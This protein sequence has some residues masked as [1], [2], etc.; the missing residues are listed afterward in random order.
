MML[1]FVPKQD[2]ASRGGFAAQSTQLKR[3]IHRCFV[4]LDPAT[5]TAEDVMLTAY[6]KLLLH[7]EQR[8]AYRGEAMP[9]FEITGV[10]ALQNETYF[11]VVGVYL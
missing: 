11:E 9:T 1:S 2:I 5:T 10:W 4:Q 7:L 6:N 3:Y 8:S